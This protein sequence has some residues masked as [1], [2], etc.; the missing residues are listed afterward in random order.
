MPRRDN[1]DLSIFTF[2][3]GRRTGDFFHDVLEHMDFQNLD[4]LSEGARTQAG[5]LRFRAHITPP[6]PSINFCGNWSKS[7]SSGGMSLRDTPKA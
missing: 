4:G 2:D 6:W 7:S 5:R 1:I 3:R